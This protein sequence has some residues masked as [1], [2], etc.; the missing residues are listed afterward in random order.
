MSLSF[1]LVVLVNNLIALKRF[2]TFLSNYELWEKPTWVHKWA[3]HRA[4]GWIGRES[5]RIFNEIIKEVQ[6]APPVLG[7]NDCATDMFAVLHI[8]LHVLPADAK[9]LFNLMSETELNFERLKKPRS[10]LKVGD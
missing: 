6:D 7:L 8:A 10:D 1:N 2:N 9:D 4:R 5:L 3:I